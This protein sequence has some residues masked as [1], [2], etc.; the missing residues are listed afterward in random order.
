LTVEEVID[1]AKQY[2]Y[3]GVELNGKRPHCYPLEMTNNRCQDIR[4][5]AAD[6]GV[7]ISAL[8][9]NN[10]FSSPIPEHRESQ[11]IA[12]REVMRVASNMG[13]KVIRVFLASPGVTQSLEQ[14]GGSYEFAKK[15]WDFEHQ[16][17]SKEQIW[18]W[19]RKGMMES[20]RYAR[21]FGVTMALVNHPP[22]IKDYHDVLRMVNEVDS[23]NLMASL[24]PPMMLEEQKTELEI[25]KAVF[26]VGQLLKMSRFSGD[27]NRGPDGKVTGATVPIYPYFVRALLDLGYQGHISYEL[28]SPIPEA[29]GTQALQEVERTARMAAEF[30]RTTIKEAEQVPRQA[31]A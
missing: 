11:V 22:V 15:V 5:Y 18:D 2:G 20:T 14:G 30:M 21:E 28:C 26:A 10:D 17:Y 7:K 24:E 23:P 1:H 6:K 4:K 27:F 16:G 13:A 9:G 3:D 8:A 12:L 29:K 31:H 25:R 19:C